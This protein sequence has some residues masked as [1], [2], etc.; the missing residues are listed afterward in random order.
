MLPP[1]GVGAGEGARDGEG[2]IVVPGVALGLGFGVAAGA[3]HASPSRA[4]KPISNETRISVGRQFMAAPTRI[5]RGRFPPCECCGMLAPMVMRRLLGIGGDSAASS[6][7]QPETETVRRIARELSQ[8]DPERRRF[9][10]G[11]AYVLSRA[12]HA[13]LAITDD[14]TR[15]MELIVTEIGGLP[16]AQAV[17]V[18]EIAK[19]QTEFYGATE[20]YLVTREFAERATQE[21]RHAVVEACFAVVAA[22]HEITSVEYAELTAIATELGLTRAELNV[23]RNE[24]KDHLTAIQRMRSQATG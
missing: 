21:Q 9:L 4:D 17:L 15:Q 8:V 24:Y 12:A 13:D 20:D 10:A 3:P 14:E 22:D 1:D 18:V 5:A 6:S 19:H 16:E 2:G 23:V 11:F 7:T